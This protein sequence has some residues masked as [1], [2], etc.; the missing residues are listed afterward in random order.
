M[1]LKHH[2]WQIMIGH[3]GHFLLDFF[4]QILTKGSLR[5][6]LGPIL[7]HFSNMPLFRWF[8]F[9]LKPAYSIVHDKL[10]LAIWYTSFWI[11]WSN[12]DTRDIETYPRAYSGHFEIC[13]FLAI[14]GPFEYF[15]ENGWSHKIKVSS[16]KKWSLPHYQFN[17]RKACP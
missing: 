3:L 14:P 4:G 9:T 6:I 12:L 17:F 5:N 11:F 13:H 8:K 10:W 16:M 7:S 15:S 1:S 2:A